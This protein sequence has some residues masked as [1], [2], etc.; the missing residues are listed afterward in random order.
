V[1]RRGDGLFA[2]H[3]AMVV[4]DAALGVT[5][6]VRG[7]DLLAWAVEAWQPERRPAADAIAAAAPINRSGD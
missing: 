1:I 4:D 6:V 2:Y 5:D 7:G 3:L